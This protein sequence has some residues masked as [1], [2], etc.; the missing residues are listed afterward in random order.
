VFLFYAVHYPYPEKEELLLQRMYEFGELIKKQLGVL[1][2]NTFR[3]SEN[4]TLIA[5][6]IWESQEAFQTAWPVLVKDAPSEELE[7]KPREVHL[8]HSAL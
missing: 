1:F 5:L 7:F 2:V 6:A 8:L 3:D 4:G